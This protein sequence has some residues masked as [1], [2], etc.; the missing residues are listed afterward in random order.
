[1]LGASSSNP[2]LIDSAQ[3]VF[4]GSGTARTLTATPLADQ[5][6]AA[7]ITLSVSDGTNMATEVFK[8]TVTALVE[9]LAGSGGAAGEA[10]SGT[11]GASG[12]AAHG[13]EGGAAAGGEQDASVDAVDASSDGGMPASD[14]DGCDCSVPGHNAPRTKSVIGLL[15]GVFGLAARRSRR[16]KR[17]VSA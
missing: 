11:G 15:V 16:R 6:G 17:I 13:G 14:K 5:S 3:V 1:V 9:P 2:G 4:G 7:D 12:A 8:L 10:E